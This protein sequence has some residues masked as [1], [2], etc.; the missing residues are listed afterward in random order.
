MGQ[1]ITS[2]P[3]PK[4]VAGKVF[5]GAL[6]PQCQ[7]G[8]QVMVQEIEVV[9]LIFTGVPSGCALSVLGALSER[10]EKFHD[11]VCD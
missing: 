4:R 9:E 11:L 10:R 2:V 6:F 7:T 1:V 8:Q 3:S 5:E